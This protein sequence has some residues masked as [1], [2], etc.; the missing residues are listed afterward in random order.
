MEKSYHL[1]YSRESS[2]VSDVA[3]YSIYIIFL[4]AT[5]PAAMLP[6]TIYQRIL[7]NQS[8]SLLCFQ[9]LLAPAIKQLMKDGRNVHFFVTHFAS[10]REWQCIILHDWWIGCLINPSKRAKLTSSKQHC[11]CFWLHVMSCKGWRVSG[12]GNQHETQSVLKNGFQLLLDWQWR[13]RIF[14]L[15]WTFP[16]GFFWGIP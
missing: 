10:F 14:T 1:V 13:R 15:A 2:L 11:S 8:L 6:E 4:I 16:L 3:T 9:F 5:P 12:V 7:W